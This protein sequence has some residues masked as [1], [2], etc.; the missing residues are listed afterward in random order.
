MSQPNTLLTPS[1][2]YPEDSSTPGATSG[3]DDGIDPVQAY[4][5]NWGLQELINAAAYLQAQQ[6]GTLAAPPNNQPPVISA[7]QFGSGVSKVMTLPPFTSLNTSGSGAFQLNLL[8]ADDLTVVM[9]PPVGLYVYFSPMYVRPTV[10]G[11]AIPVP[12]WVTGHTPATLDRCWSSVNGAYYVCINALGANG[13][14]DPG[15]VGAPS[16]GQGIAPSVSDG[17]NYW[18]PLTSNTFYFPTPDM[19]PFLIVNWAGNTNFARNSIIQVGAGH[20]WIALNSG[21]SQ[22]LSPFPGGTPAVGTTQVDNAGPNQITWEF[23][24]LDIPSGYWVRIGQGYGYVQQP[25]DITSYLASDWAPDAGTGCYFWKDANGY[26]HIEGQ[27]TYSTGGTAT[28]G[29]LPYPYWP[30]KVRNFVINNAT[31][32][33]QGGAYVDSTGNIKL[34]TAFTLTNT[35]S[36]D[37]TPITYLAQI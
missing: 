33:T 23:I 9:I 2:T 20:Y 16:N 31:A 30:A 8:P 37:L 3:P 12:E 1:Q 11:A 10:G 18:T 25:L 36:Y 29:T 28:I 32:Q 7:Y 4:T 15:S 24:G 26:V 17:K 35:Q 14:T 34:Y 6:S 21:E 19:T 5:V 13:A 27:V 22:A